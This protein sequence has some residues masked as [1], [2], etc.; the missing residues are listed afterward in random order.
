MSGVERESPA[1]A[2]RWSASA[3]EIRL[4]WALIRFVAV[5]SPRSLNSLYPTWRAIGPI[6]YQ[7]VSTYHGIR[8]SFIDDVG[9]PDTVEEIVAPDLSGARRETVSGASIEGANSD[10]RV[11]EHRDVG[12]RYR[13]G[14]EQFLVRRSP[15][16]LLDFDVDVRMRLL[17]RS[18]LGG[19]PPRAPLPRCVE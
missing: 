5:T 1:A 18:R 11:A 8:T 2:I 14:G 4:I 15:R 3:A 6:E 13:R 10:P 7:T 12:C 19:T 17:E 9:L 16:D